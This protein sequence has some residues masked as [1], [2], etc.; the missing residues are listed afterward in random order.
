MEQIFGSTFIA[1]KILLHKKLSDGCTLPTR[2]VFK[3][4]GVK[5]K[6]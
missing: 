3:E 6:S 5:N 4:L 2:R 1:P